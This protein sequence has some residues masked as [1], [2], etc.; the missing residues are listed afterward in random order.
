MNR[1]SKKMIEKAAEKND[2]RLFYY[3]EG[4]YDY[5]SVNIR[6]FKKSPSVTHHFRIH[7]DEFLIFTR[8]YSNKNKRNIKTLDQ[9]ERIE[10]LIIESYESTGSRRKSL[11]FKLGNA[12]VKKG[13]TRKIA[14]QRA[15]SIVQDPGSIVLSEDEKSLLSEYGVNY[16]REKSK[17][18]KVPKHKIRK[19]IKEA[20]INKNKLKIYYK[21]KY[22]FEV[23]VV[24]PRII[25][26]YALC[27][28]NRY[29]RLILRAFQEKG[30]STFSRNPKNPI[31]GWRTF[32][33]SQISYLEVL[34]TNFKK[35]RPGYNQSGDKQFTVL[36]Q[37][38][39]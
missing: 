16:E 37:A 25:E 26:P 39:F 3:S 19:A 33:L 5:V 1:I 22:A 7:S 11:M 30:P 31:P 36:L 12:L 24:G 15:R 9:R 8:T 29:K 14:F 10:N 6:R 35:P 34:S 23:K 18:R 20:I 17:S 27:E 28:T 32:A 13:F 38:K 21:D 4:G 2:W